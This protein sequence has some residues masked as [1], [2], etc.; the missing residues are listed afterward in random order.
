[1]TNHIHPIGQGAVSRVRM[2]ASVTCA[3][4][5]R[6]VVE[7]GADI[8]DAKDP[9]RGALGAVDADT[10]RAIRQAVPPSRLLSATVG[11]IPASDPDRVV[12]ACHAVDS[13][14][15]DFVKIG[16]F[17]AGAGSLM[18]RLAVERVAFGRRIAVLMADRS[19]DLDL[20]PELRVA[21][22][23]GVMLDTAD[24]AAGALPEV[25]GRCQLQAFVTTARRHGLV[26]GLAGALR[27][28]HV[29]GLAALG[30]DV[31]GFRGALCTGSER[32]AAVSRPAVV[33]VRE[34]L[35]SSPVCDMA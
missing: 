5:A 27:L 14:G 21:G 7:C 34:A 11:D 2:L 3:E 8:V 35:A 28:M 19:P 9:A 18:S 20:I 24:K 29:A 32:T 4:E 26:A 12:A 10:L 17:G 15:P 23:K 30:P 31:I 13:C 25:M 6:L 1:M 33:A 22:F 16:F